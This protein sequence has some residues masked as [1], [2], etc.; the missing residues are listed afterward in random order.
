MRKGITYCRKYP[1]YTRYLP[2]RVLLLILL[3]LVPPP[4]LLHS[5]LS[6]GTE[7]ANQLT[8]LFPLIAYV[9]LHQPSVRAGPLAPAL[10]TGVGG[11]GVTVPHLAQH[12][13][14][15][16]IH[17]LVAMGQVQVLWYSFS[18]RELTF[19]YGN[20]WLTLLIIETFCNEDVRMHTLCLQSNKEKP[21]SDTHKIST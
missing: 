20:C 2:C 9:C 11:L 5:T 4:F 7:A 13:Q 1:D 6:P 12:I 17:P 18:F 14:H 10:G 19:F 8:G 3:L 21:P 16:L 15:A